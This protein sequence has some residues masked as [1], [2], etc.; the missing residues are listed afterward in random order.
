MGELLKCRC[1]KDYEQAKK[2]FT[3]E[4]K[5]L[6]D[7]KNLKSLNKLLEKIGLHF[8]QRLIEKDKNRWKNVSMLHRGS[9][10]MNSTTNT[11]EATHGH[12]NRKTPRNNGFLSSIFRLAFSL[13]IDN[14]FIKN[15]IKH[16][17]N[18]IKKKTMNIKNNLSIETLRR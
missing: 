5:A 1:E 3:E 8:N 9:Y 11:L 7:K 15:K 16:T 13:R 10:E 14:E 17:Y 12:L 4:Y 6:K 18:H 2:T